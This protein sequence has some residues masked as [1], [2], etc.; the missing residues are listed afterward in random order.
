MIFAKDYKYKNIL[1]VLFF[2]IFF[3][4]GIFIHNDYGIS[5]DENFHRTN[6]Q[7]SLNYIKEFTNEFSLSKFFK[8][9]LPNLDWN[10]FSNNYGVIF[11]VFLEYLDTKI[12]F[13]DEKDFFIFKHFL[14]FIVFFIATIFFFD[15]IATRFDWRIGLFGSL[16]LILS[17]RIFADSF[18]NMKD[19]IFMSLLIISMNTGSKYL[20]NP[21]IMTIF[22]FSIASGLLIAVRSIGIFLPIIIIFLTI[23]QYYHRSK[24][25]KNLLSNNLL[26]IILL[27]L[28]TILFWPRLW[29]SP[30]SNFISSLIVMKNYIWSEEIFYLGE[31]V[32]GK[33]VPWHYI[34]VWIS[35]STPLLYIILFL[36]G[37]FIILKRFLNRL[38]KIDDTKKNY[39]DFWR[40]DKELL[41]LFFVV[42]FFV[43][44][45]AMIKFNS[46]LYDGWR[47]A[48]FLY[49]PLLMISI[50]GFYHLNIIFKKLK[51]KNYF[52]IFISLFI[53]TIF[54]KMVII[55]PYQNVY[56]NFLAGKNPGQYFELDYWSL[57]NREILEKLLKKDSSEKIKI[58]VSSDTPLQ[59]TIN[60]MID[61]N[62]RNRIII[63]ENIDESDYI[64]NNYRF[65]HGEY[66]I[67]KYNFDET[68]FEIFEQVKAGEI[69]IN[70]L[71]KNK[72]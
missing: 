2:L 9:E 37:V 39:N 47:H 4:L 60:Y 52:L 19:L 22:W 3:I 54:F 67:N 6:G 12:G 1:I 58:W 14:N 32:R 13:S 20:I 57:S 31:Y 42:L 53:V 35:I 34:P 17:P 29:Q 64:L 25:L 27:C 63:V 26:L 66:S 51:F 61:K 28:F 71:Y 49:P 5:W 15:L 36:I 24:S 56:F 68:Q 45:F 16:L 62:D 55:H 69:I 30:Y 18:Y 33:I 23:L 50:F 48:F 46:T 8:Y 10:T 70:S 59:K 38:D 44:L 72:K 7:I 21:N 65:L 40:G 43:P 11:D 41:D